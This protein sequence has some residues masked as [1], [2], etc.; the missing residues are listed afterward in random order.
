MPSLSRNF[1]YPR[2][3]E[4]CFSFLCDC[5]HLLEKQETSCKH[6]SRSL[7]ASPKPSPEE[8]PAEIVAELPET[9]NPIISPIRLRW[10]QREL[11]FYSVI[12]LVIVFYFIDTTFFPPTPSFYEQESFLPQVPPPSIASKK[13]SIPKALVNSQQVAPLPQIQTDSS[14]THLNPLDPSCLVQE[15]KET[16]NSFSSRPQMVL[17]EMK[18][19]SPPLEQSPQKRETPQQAKIFGNFEAEVG[20]GFFFLEAQSPLRTLAGAPPLTFRWELL[21]KPLSSNSTLEP[22]GK[23]C[24]LIPDEVGSYIVRLTVQRETQSLQKTVQLQARLSPLDQEREKS[25]AIKKTPL[26][27]EEIPENGDLPKKNIPKKELPPPLRPLKEEQGELPPMTPRMKGILQKMKGSRS[28]EELLILLEEITDLAIQEST[29]KEATSLL[30]GLLPYLQSKMWEVRAGTVYALGK[31]KRIE[32]I[33]P[34]ILLLKKERTRVVLDIQE[35]LTSI[36]H[37]DFGSK[38]SRWKEF[39]DRNKD[40]FVRPK[41]ASQNEGSQ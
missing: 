33:E 32:A 26:E 3:R 24:R 18:E 5:G 14:A 28:L 1:S 17:S 29:H 41:L 35:A 23:H 21:D 36:T 30:P 16:K 22:S 4:F 34:L 10:N 37:L 38:H 12:A 15:T 8:H 31:M 27:T 39:W 11:I 19:G 9:L 13:A 2:F 7:Y 40:S 6:C 20:I 25:I